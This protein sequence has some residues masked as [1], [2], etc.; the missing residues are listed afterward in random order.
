MKPI[1]SSVVLLSSLVF[2]AASPADE[3][4]G[5]VVDRVQ[6]AFD[7]LV[8]AATHTNWPSESV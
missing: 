1:V 5:P 2:A 4:G 3:P 6:T 7:K 8:R